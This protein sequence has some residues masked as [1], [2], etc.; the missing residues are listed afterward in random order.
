MRVV[1]AA[2]RHLLRAPS[3]SAGLVALVAAAIAVYAGTAMGLA[4]LDD[5][6]TRLYDELGL[7]DF[8][9]RF[10]PQDH[11]LLSRLI[12]QVDGVEDAT[13][14][15]LAP[16]V[17]TLP[18]G[19]LAA[20]AVLAIPGDEHPAVGDLRVIEGRWIAGRDETVIDATF[21]RD[22]GLGLGDALSLRL[23]EKTG[24]LEIVGIGVHPEFLLA[25]I[26]DHFTMPVRGTV[27]AMLV[28]QDVVSVGEAVPVNSLAVRLH[29]G[30]ELQEVR[31]ALRVRLLAGGVLHSTTLLREHQYSV[32]CHRNRLIAFS[33]FL[34]TVLATFVLLA[35]L[36]VLAAARQ[37]ALHWREPVGTLLALGHPP[38][39]LLLAWGI[40][41]GV[42]V[43]LGALLGSIGAFALAWAVTELYVD[44]L[45]LPLVDAPWR[46]GPLGLALGVTV[47]VVWPAALLPVLPLLRQ[48][49]APLLRDA[50]RQSATTGAWSAV[51]RRLDRV[52]P[53]PERL[54]ARS[55]LRRPGQLVISVIGVAGGLVLASSMYTYADAQ[56]D[57]VDTFL[58]ARHWDVWVE[59]RGERDMAAARSVLESAGATQWEP[60]RLAPAVL[61]ANGREK[62]QQAIG[63]LHA[64]TL[65][66]SE[67]L[68]Y[69]RGLSGP[70]ASEV[71][72]SVR[73]LQD[74]A[75]ELGD[76]VEVEIAGEAHQHRIVGVV[77]GWAFDQV[78][79]PT[80]WLGEGVDGAIATGPASM[81]R[82]LQAD[83]NIAR[84]LPGA[85]IADSAQR[86]NGVLL[87]AMRLYGH[88]GAAVA[89]ILVFASLQLAVTERADEFATLRSLG[90]GPAA[91]AR[92]LA[93]E[94]L[95][96]AILAAILAVPLT[97]LVTAV[98]AMRNLENGIVITVPADPVTVGL[99]LL[100]PIAVML[101][102]VGPALVSV[103]RLDLPG[104]LR[105]R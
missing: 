94:A 67:G 96:V 21:A 26:D 73:A 92:V 16:G 5:T 86:A 90:W 60:V 14:R 46:I 99:S 4:R 47:G 77:N 79:V 54:G 55:A 71:V 2:I 49:P 34:P 10:A 1:L 3:R 27:A 29:E 81:V 82:T 19:D 59:F 97:R 62:T 50:P 11:R 41:L 63:L 61:R 98:F 28:S 85:A 88:F 13:L 52:L 38:S 8:E 39:K 43:A 58:A 66:T 64:S 57:T 17:L 70:D 7:F 33:R 80:G 44:G 20:A 48:E 83:P 56:Y 78:S 76:D 12:G 87:S 35:V 25:S 51:L 15:T 42:P 105:R 74:L 95:L 104:L 9:V 89:L 6:A 53:P 100:V 18:S 68:V 36:L 23:G 45:G 84:V 69:G 31:D 103:Q 72:V 65:Q 30:A 91:L 22:L 75:L 24:A 93:A 32:A 102:A 37:L 40:A 101:V